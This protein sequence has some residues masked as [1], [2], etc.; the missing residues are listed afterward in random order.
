[1]CLITSKSQTLTF[2][3]MQSLNGRLLDYNRADREEI[4]VPEMGGTTKAGHLE[5]HP[6]TILLPHGHL[7]FC[8]R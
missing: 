7:K 8:Q 1:M 2:M 4:P 3:P 5:H 6:P